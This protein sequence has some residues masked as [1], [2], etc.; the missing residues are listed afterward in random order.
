[1][2]ELVEIAFVLDDEIG[3]GEPLGA[4]GLA[5]DAQARV[6]LGEPTLRDQTRDGYLGVD[7]D[8]DDA[9]EVLVAA[10]DEE[11]DVEQQ[12]GVGVV[13]QRAA[14][15]HLVDDCGMHDGVE[16][17]ELVRIGEHDA[18]D[19]G[20][21]ERPVGQQDVGV[22]GL[23]HAREHRRAG[24]LHLAHDGIGV[25]E[26][27]APSDQLLRH[28]RF[29]GADAARQPKFDHPMTV[30]E[31]RPWTEVLGSVDPGQKNHSA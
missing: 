31:A 29:S 17:G 23:R 2:A 13:V 14:P 3:A 24:A 11:R 26:H 22:E 30:A 21:V 8:H 9:P 16:R 27:R 15:R 6:V 10:L 1:L 7:V 18:R 19:L 12:R 5:R 28:G 4:T 20:P 25:D